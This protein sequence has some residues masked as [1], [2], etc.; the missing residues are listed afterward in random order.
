MPTLAAPL[1]FLFV[2]D[3]RGGESVAAGAPGEEAE[4]AFARA[5]APALAS[6]CL[7]CHGPSR[8]RSGLRVDSLAALLKGGKRG[9]ALVPGDP[10]A[11]R[12]VAAIRRDDPELKMPPDRTLPAEVAAAFEEW[13]RGGAPWP[14]GFEL[15]APD[16]SNG[17][18]SNE[19]AS[20]AARR[21]DEVPGIPD[22]WAFDPPR[23][24]E[25]PAVPSAGFIRD[26]ID[27]W[28][29]ARLGAAGLAPSPPADRRTLIRR[30]TLDVTGLP[31][32][33]EEVT[34]FVADERPDAF[35]RLVDRLLA[36]PRYGERCAADWL[37]VV[38]FAETNGFEPNLPRPQAWPYRDWLVRAFN[39][40]RPWSDFVRAQLCGDQLGEDEATGFLVAGAWDEVKSP[41]PVL[42]AVQRDDELHGMVSRT[43]AAFLGLTAGCAK[44][45][46]HKFDPVGQGDYYA[47]RA[48]FE[49]VQFGTRAWRREGPAAGGGAL[50]GR[51][52]V[53]AR[54]NVERFE[55]VVARRLRFVANATNV[56]EPCLD[57]LEILSVGDA[58]SDAGGTRANVA[59][60][61]F[62]AVAR[63]SS[64]FLD[65]P[66]HTLEHVNDGR[67]GNDHS[68]IPREVR[69]WVEIELAR[70]TPIDTVVWG[71][72]REGAFADRLPT[73]YRIEVL[74][75][76][77]G[78]RVVASSKDRRP[79]LP[80][81]QVYAGRFDPAPPATRR[82]ERG[83]PMEPREP[84][85]PGGVAR[86][87][88]PF[89]LADVDSEPAR[90]RALAE[91]IA[92]PCN[93]L[94]ARA[95]VNRIW[96]QHFGR[97]LVET[98]SDFGAMGA[99]PSHPELL[100]QLALDLIGGGFRLKPIHRRILL[101]ST[102][103]QSS[104]PRAE[105]LEQDA[106]GR[107]LWRFPPRRL[108]A[109]AIRDSMLSVAGTLDPR[110]GGPSVSPFL[111]N[112]NY[113][114]VYE[115]KT[116]F[117]PGDFR[118]SIYLMRVRMHPDATFGAFDAPDGGQPCPRRA[119]SNTPLQ[120]LAL[121]HA[122]FVQEVAR[123]F[124]ARLER[125]H[126]D[127]GLDRR[128]ARA[129]D[130]AFQRTPAADELACALELAESFGLA[131][132]CRALLA[133]SE[134]SW[135]E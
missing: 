116:E 104:A 109:E 101:S 54:R 44:C 13:I 129:F 87:G 48:C 21:E 102:W 131:S 59:L 132:C 56:G 111:P 30:A 114:R 130:L 61:S 69:G 9:P 67:Y 88:V 120:A 108:P 82:L 84:L 91:W 27:A 135:I 107:L 90:R 8:Q 55:P 89:E 70:P 40:D 106:D 43:S 7:R 57:E 99:R 60:S 71:R 1:C 19:A 128:V 81:P 10:A 51:E 112:D 6:E 4:R 24:T 18:G 36:S 125:E 80:E 25:L 74:V 34:T 45:H 96:Q 124:A 66:R 78:W 121:M 115:P 35:E 97:G 65:D 105:A 118:R 79:P 86:L 76:G 38:G 98:P 16:P 26:P 47:L 20:S 2:A 94:T 117:G 53:N 32:T 46:D 77:A 22:D 49:G 110:M 14:E 62:G 100:D 92:S 64:V 12:I 58:A 63:A 28:V 68:W 113:V 23:A 5:V 29:A 93:P 15:P 42:T 127:A 50:P 31:P 52:P 75:E 3:L 123:R 85:A 17:A 83:E 33:P 126:G 39:Q 11:S 95:V 103:R 72:D 37:D 119:I 122:P 73:D 41:D 134:L 133:A